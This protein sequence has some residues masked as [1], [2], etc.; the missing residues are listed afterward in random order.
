MDT[1][2]EWPQDIARCYN[3]IRVL[4]TGGFAS[5]VL[6]SKKAD[7]INTPT[8]T[9]SSSSSSLVA[10][11]QKVAIKVVGCND[12]SGKNDVASL[13]ARREIELLQQ[14][15]HAGVVKLFH[16]WENKTNRDNENDEETNSNGQRQR[17]KQHPSPTAGVLVLEYLKGPTVESLLTH[18]GALSSLFGRLV[19]AQLMDAVAYLH[20]RAVLHRDIK[21]DNVIVTGA[22]SSDPF[23]WDNDAIENG[24]VISTPMV[25]DS[26][27]SDEWKK[28]CFKYRIKIID[29]GFAR[30]LTPEDMEQKPAKASASR[31]ESPSRR[32]PKEKEAGYHN[33]HSDAL[34]HI[35]KKNAG[36]K[37]NGKLVRR[38]YGSKESLSELDDSIRSNQ[39]DDSIRSNQSVSHKMIRVMSTLGNRHFAAPEILGKVR[40]ITPQEKKAEIRDHQKCAS[41]TTNTISEYVANYGVLADSYSMGHT[42][43]YMMTGVRPGVS[44]EDTIR[45]QQRSRMTKKVLIKLGLK[46]KKSTTSGEQTKKKPRKP[47]YRSL[48]DTPGMILVLVEELTEISVH[49]RVSIRKARRY[50]WISDVLAFQEYNNNKTHHHTPNDE[51]TTNELNPAVVTT[52]LLPEPSLEHVSEEQLHELHETRYLPLAT[53]TPFSGVS[54]QTTKTFVSL[55]HSSSQLISAEMHINPADDDDFLV[56]QEF[57]DAGGITF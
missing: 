57:D 35:K 10:L 5:V 30:A 45:K 31:S 33:V 32:H 34:I 11:R 20:Y 6:A 48:N 41:G 25:R 39:L 49:R 42:I 29:F 56:A 1:P 50:P 15:Q 55:N 7:A 9:D 26:K 36:G 28:L 3:P 23:I 12:G 14:I 40:H 13:Y 2:K 43:R 19:I 51:E 53:T 22:L 47:F 8:P 27:S 17:Q 16:S 21:P 44:V 18:G 4:G 38:F 54:T 37:T 46:K 52:S 24:D